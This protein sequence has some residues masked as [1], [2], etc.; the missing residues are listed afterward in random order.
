MASFGSIGAGGPGLFDKSKGIAFDTFGNIYVADALHGLQI[1]NPN[2]QPLMMFAKGFVQT[3]TGLVID[4]RNHIFVSDPV[5]PMV[6]EFE[7]INT[8]AEDS[9]QTVPAPAQ[10]PAEGSRNPP[11]PAQDTAKSPTGG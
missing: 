3:P 6:H 9:F 10:A 1:F 5:S 7:L 11:P 2:F 4:S 8:T